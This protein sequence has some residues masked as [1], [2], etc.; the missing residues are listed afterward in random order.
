MEGKIKMTS[1]EK[2]KKELIEGYAY[3]F[4]QMLYDS[5]Y[6][7]GYNLQEFSSE[8]IEEMKQINDDDEIKKGQLTFDF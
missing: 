7:K 8:V 5:G 2:L 3:S 1:E 6:A 4:L